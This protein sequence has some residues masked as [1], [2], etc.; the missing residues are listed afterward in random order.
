MN[1]RKYKLI[2]ITSAVIIAVLIV[3][4]VALRINYLSN[5]RDDDSFDPNAVLIDA[6]TYGRS[7]R[8]PTGSE[9]SEIGKLVIQNNISICGEYHVKE[10]TSG[11]YLIACSPDGINWQYFVAY[12]KIGKFYRASDEMVEKLTP[13]R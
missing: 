11:E 5:H 13:P 12:P 7:W 10:V 2:G 1:V 3:G 4:L 8:S 9:Y 6:N